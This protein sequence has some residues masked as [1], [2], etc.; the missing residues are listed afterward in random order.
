MVRVTLSVW[1][2][3]RVAVALAVGWLVLLV[4]ELVRV[5]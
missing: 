1:L 5:L 4:Y 3:R 2:P